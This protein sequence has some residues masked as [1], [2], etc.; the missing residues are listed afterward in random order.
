[1]EFPRLRIGVG[2]P[3]PEDAADYVLGRFS[4]DEEEVAAAAVS[5]AADAIEETLA[6]GLAAA[7]NR[8][9]G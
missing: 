1:N 9:N 4:R 7:M 8:Y 2:R 5:R 3:R 6:S